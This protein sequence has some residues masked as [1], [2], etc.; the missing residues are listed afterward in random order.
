MVQSTGYFL[1]GLVFSSK[2][3]YWMTHNPLSLQ[4]QGVSIIFWFLQ[5]STHT[6]L[7]TLIYIHAYL[8]TYKHTYIKKS[9][10]NEK[11]YF[12]KDTLAEWDPR[13]WILIG[14]DKS[15]NLSPPSSSYALWSCHSSTKRW[16]TF[17]YPVEPDK[18]NESSG[19]MKQVSISYWK[20][21]L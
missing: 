12:D 11:N 1:R 3:S 17:L 9:L 4:L 2:R 16:D 8:F 14:E 18:F 21:Y 5:A 20:L 13:L 7:H 19:I 6:C 10:K 15:N